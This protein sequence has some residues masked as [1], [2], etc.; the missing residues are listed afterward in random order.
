MTTTD[1]ATSMAYL[2]AGCGRPLTAEAAEVYFDLLGDLPARAL[3]I[4]VK[5][6]LLESSFTSFPSVGTLRKL[7]TEA[8]Q[9]TDKLPVAMEAWEQV[10][11]AVR[12]FGLSGQDRALKSLPP[13]VARTARAVGWQCL[14]DARLENLD[15]LRAHFLKAYDAVAGR[16]QREALLPPPLKAVLAQ[17]GREGSSEPDT[18]TAREILGPVKQI[19][20]MP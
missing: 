12:R 4:A 15:V 2:A 5:R 13:V 10:S 20:R 18:R 17:I 7:A 16:E 11:A 8:L 1:F 9:G 14:C 6:A 19:G 3:Q